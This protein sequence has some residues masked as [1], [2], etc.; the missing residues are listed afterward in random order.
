MVCTPE[1]NR[2]FGMAESKRANPNLCFSCDN[3]LLTAIDSSITNERLNS[4]V[5]TTY[6]SETPDSY[7]QNAPY[8]DF[9]RRT[10]PKLCRDFDSADFSFSHFVFFLESQKTMHCCRCNTPFSFAKRTQ[11]FEISQIIIFQLHF[12]RLIFLCIRGG[13]SRG[14]CL[15]VCECVE[16]SAVVITSNVITIEE[17]IKLLRCA[18]FVGFFRQPRS[19]LQHDLA[20]GGLLTRY[21]IVPLFFL[22]GL[23]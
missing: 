4:G 10:Q 23:T 20:V 17:Q 3:N 19:C 14:G 12:R 21:K 9:R 8:D 15:R 2:S 13:F 16:L 1:F 22:A 7:L 6:N 11:T 5:R 18:V